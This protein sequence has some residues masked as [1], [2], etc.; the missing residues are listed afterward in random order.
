MVVVVVVVMV[1]S[2]WCLWVKRL[3]AEGEASAM[4]LTSLSSLTFI[5]FILHAV[6]TASEPCSSCQTAQ[7]ARGS[8]LLQ[9]RTQKALKVD[10]TTLSY[11]EFQGFVEK[12]FARAKELREYSQR[13][14]LILQK[15]FRSF[16]SSHYKSFSQNLTCIENVEQG[17]DH[18]VVTSKLDLELTPLE[19]QSFRARVVE[20]ME[21]LCKHDNITGHAQYVADFMQALE[22]ERPVLTSKLQDI[23]KEQYHDV[24]FEFAGWLVN[25][26]TIDVQQRTGLKDPHGPHDN[27]TQLLQMSQRTVERLQRLI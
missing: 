19:L 7:T 17:F 1:V 2:P 8:E 18:F 11:E 22:D 21:Y 26:T 3:C 15:S 14:K 13:G 9:R 6:L 24:T 16:D 10:T 25:F 12:S 5:L 27:R 23:L 20:E 4:A